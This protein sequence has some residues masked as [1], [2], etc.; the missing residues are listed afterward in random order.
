MEAEF[1][2]GLLA[3]D[4]TRTDKDA[5]KLQAALFLVAIALVATAAPPA[6]EQPK[7][8]EKHGGEKAAAISA[9]AALARLKR[10]N[11]RF[12]HGHLKHPD[13]GV[14][15]VHT[16]A[17]G[18]HPIAAV[19]SCADS[20]VPPE[21]VFDEGLG[22]LFV[23]REAGH[24]ADDATLGSLEYAVHHLGVPLI[25]VLG[26]EKC[27]AVSATV[28]AMKAH[29]RGEGHIARLV[30][31]IRPAVTEAGPGDE[32]TLVHR[33]VAANV[34]LVVRQLTASHP[35]LH[36]A[37]KAAKVRIVGAVYDIDTGIV[38]WK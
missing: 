19:L 17:M 5:M 10:G 25:V 9:D 18:Q 32:A 26:H 8:D 13:Q 36:E 7:P 23:V 4:G 12:A 22:D 29:K 30:H 35:F 16:L 37:R 31:D 27:G 33:A 6:K 14:D 11:S 15:R 2:S 21:I 24:V 20:R 1:G 38:H 3:C 34:D 28:E